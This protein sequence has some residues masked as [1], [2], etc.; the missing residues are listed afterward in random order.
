MKIVC[1]ACAAKYSIADDK[2][3][4]KVF[5]IRCK[6]CSNIIV[7][8][9]NAGAADEPAAGPYDQ[10][11]TRVYDYGSQ[12]GGAAAPADDV[13][14]HVVIDQEQVGPI[15]VADVQ[16]RFAAGELDVESYVW[17]EGFAD[18][19]PLSQVPEFA[20]LA[21]G[22]STTTA[23]PGS[24]GQD[25]VASMFGSA[26]FDAAPAAHASEGDVFA[27]HAAKAAAVADDAGG[28]LFG[29]VA[30]PAPEA[31][32]MAARAGGTPSPSAVSA[33][34]KGQRSE[35]SVLFSLNN[36][37]AMASDSRPAAAP[38]SS[39]GA[40]HGGGEGSGLID[41]RSMASSY[42]G[43]KGAA[44]AR[45]G[46]AVGSVDDIPVFSTATFAE[47]AVIMPVSGGARNN[48]T[49][50]ILLG[51]VGLLAAAAVVL[52]VVMMSKN[53]KN[54]GSSA[55]V[56]T[57]TGGAGSAGSAGAAAGSDL[58]ATGPTHPDTQGPGSSA[59]TPP[60]PPPANIGGSAGS[61]AG[62]AGDTTGSSAGSAAS[63]TTPEPSHATDKPSHA[64]DKPEHAEHAAEHGSEHDKPAKP[65]RVASV[66]E[67]TTAAP[68]KPEKPAKGDK[69][70]AGGCIDEVACLL[71]DPKPACCLKQGHGGGGTTTT[72]HA[73]PPPPP[74]SNLPE[75]LTKQD[76]SDGIAKIRTR[77][78]AC[79]A[80]SAAK[81][82]V[83]VT[84][85]VSGA[86]TVASVQVKE[87]PD[88]AL[89]SCVAAAVQK[90]TFPKSQ[91]GSTFT[92]PFKF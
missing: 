24:S 52:V 35:N 29:D 79:G 2:V 32:G 41:I 21:A 28:D 15:S 25:A 30:P 19:L 65:E 18:W 43:A 60:A 87:S 90:A 1:D 6:K 42:L 56:A 63:A 62:P 47:P 11:E 55:P 54:N 33:G 14:W 68:D 10:K 74:P 59:P 45:S 48:N 12:D 51:A 84:V 20:S 66:P 22:G 8:R 13:V 50:Y 73:A 40:Q 89:G 86:G 31:A 5:K 61:A 76:I 37:A 44:P 58:V 38:S 91:E 39:G 17:R 77:A 27:A 85:K 75:Q 80:K 78:D 16:A 46:P 23:Q 82:T 26:N 92:Y 7:V 4:G 69:P 71:A 64:T 70:G 72:T 34:M 36:L 49:L 9:G 3:K 53:N 83:K 88:G 57:R 81:G 67:H